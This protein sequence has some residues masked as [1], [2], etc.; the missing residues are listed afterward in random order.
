[1]GHLV[2]L[3]PP[4]STHGQTCSWR[5]ESTCQITKCVSAG[6]PRI[7][8]VSPFK[9][10]DLVKTQTFW[11]T[12][13]SGIREE[14]VSFPAGGLGVFSGHNL[15]LRVSLA[16]RASRSFGSPCDEGLC[17]ENLQEDL[18]AGRR[19]CN[20]VMGSSLRG[21]ACSR[22]T[23]S[24]RVTFR[25]VY[26]FL[27]LSCRFSF[28]K[29]PGFS[30]LCPQCLQ[31]NS[32]QWLFVSRRR[33]GGHRKC[34]GNVLCH[35]PHPFPWPVASAQSSQRGQPPKDHPV[36]HKCLRPQASPAQ[37]TQKGSPSSV[38]SAVFPRRW[39]NRPYK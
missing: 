10:V 24:C 23:P 26:V 13:A 2:H 31:I 8:E 27:F 34:P 16:G 6:A 12:T 21:C 11:R 30:L 22:K 37:T 15:F 9:Q 14:P 7:G 28:P 29:S 32:T 3:A 39:E 38:I 1:M 25:G 18:R 20:V 35:R 36:G 5:L 19:A 17:P 4:P 33:G